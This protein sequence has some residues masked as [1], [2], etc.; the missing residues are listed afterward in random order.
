MVRVGLAITALTTLGNSEETQ[1]S[2]SQVILLKLGQMAEG[3]TDFFIGNVIE[4][5]GRA[6][7]FKARMNARIQK[8]EKHYID[9]KSKNRRRKRRSNKFGDGV[10]PNS[11]RLYDES[12]GRQLK[13]L[14]QDPVRSNSQIYVN[15]KN[16]VAVNMNECPQATKHYNKL[17][18]MQKK[19][20][21]VFDEV[22]EK[23]T[24]RRG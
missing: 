3:W 8:I 21:G 13:Q 11:E 2:P 17:E 14:S 4:R 5:P 15:L 12:T 9:C 22:L 6:E 1:R 24:K 18:A 23:I 16:W 19:W 20:T 10:A 7:N